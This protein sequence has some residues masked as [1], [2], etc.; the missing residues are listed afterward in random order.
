MAL[1]DESYD[2]ILAALLD[3]AERLDQHEHAPLNTEGAA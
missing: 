3:E 1:P 2:E